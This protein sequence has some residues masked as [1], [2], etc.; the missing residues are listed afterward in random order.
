M[1]K[2]H[3]ISIISVCSPDTLK[4]SGKTHHHPEKKGRELCPRSPYLEE[5]HRNAS[6]TA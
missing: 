1:V 5:L 3:K 4:N 6:A 2:G